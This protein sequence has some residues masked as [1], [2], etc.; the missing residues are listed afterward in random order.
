M[1]RVE[2]FEPMRRDYEKGLAVR[3][4]AGEYG[5]HRRVVRQQIES[6]TPPE[7]KV[8]DL[9]CPVRRRS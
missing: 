6:A 3:A 4:I 8:P 1:R 2:Q 9:T 7:R 5:V